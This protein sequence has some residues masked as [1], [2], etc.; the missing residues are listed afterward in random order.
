MYLSTPDAKEWGKIIKY[1]KNL[2]EIPYPKKDSKIIDEHIYQYNKEEIVKIMEETDF[3]IL[4]FA[5]SPGVINR[6]FNLMLKKK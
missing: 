1:Y 6:H 3:S 4:K 2:D 5:Y